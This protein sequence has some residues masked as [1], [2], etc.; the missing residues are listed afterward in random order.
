MLGTYAYQNTQSKTNVKAFYVLL[1]VCIQD[2]ACGV[3]EFNAVFCLARA[4]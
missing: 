1:P 4:G 3:A 2:I